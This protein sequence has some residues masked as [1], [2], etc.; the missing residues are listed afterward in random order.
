MK[1]KP[2]V[3]S[4]QG[5]CCE[6]AQIKYRTGQFSVRT[7]TAKSSSEHCGFVR[8]QN[9]VRSSRRHPALGPGRLPIRALGL[10][11]PERLND[12]RVGNT[13]SFVELSNFEF[14]ERFA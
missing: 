9:A 4:I 3:S 13:G 8:K 6:C 5:I 1:T 14:I 7:H 12:A 11:Q 2:A 10:A